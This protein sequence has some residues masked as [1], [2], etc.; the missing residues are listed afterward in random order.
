VR[1]IPCGK[2]IPEIMFLREINKFSKAYLAL[3]KVEAESICES[4]N[5]LDQESFS[6]VLGGK[7][8]VAQESPK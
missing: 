5:D 7:S 4:G 1:D 2:S 8:W 3:W 6:Y